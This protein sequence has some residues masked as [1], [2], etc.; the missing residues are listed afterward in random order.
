MELLPQALAGTYQVT[1][2]QY[3]AV[4]GSNPSSFTSG[5]DGAEV[6]GKRPVELEIL[7]VD[8]TDL[9]KWGAVPASSDATWG[10]QRH[11]THGIQRQGRRI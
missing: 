8:E 7:S 1:Q 3:E 10:Q 2:E 5:A 6:Q 9:V 4:I 11:G